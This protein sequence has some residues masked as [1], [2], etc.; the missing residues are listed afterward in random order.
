MSDNNENKN[1]ENNNENNININDN[2]VNNDN[3][4]Y[5]SNDE[6]VGQCEDIKSDEAIIEQSDNATESNEAISNESSVNE[7][8]QD[9][10]L[11]GNVNFQMVTMAEEKTDNGCESKEEEKSKE[12]CYKETVKKKSKKY[13]NAAFS[14][15]AA[16][17]LIIS[18]AGGG[19]IGASYSITQKIISDRYKDDD[20]STGDGTAATSAFIKTSSENS[21]EKGGAVP[22][23]KQVFPSVVSI[24]TKATMNK[25]Y[26]NG[27]S[28]PYEASG[29]GSGVIFYEDDTKVFIAT[30]DHVITGATSM[31]INFDKTEQIPATVVGTDSASDLAV[32]SV[33]KAD[34]KSA[35]IN[36]VSTA[37]FG[38]SDELEVG[39]SVIAIGNALGEGK[40]STGGMVSAAH[41][42]IVIDGKKLEVIQTDAAINPGNSGGAL[43]NYKGEVVGINT[44]KS[45]ESAVEGMGYAIP[46]NVLIPIIEKLL[47]DGSIEKP[48]LGIVGQDVTSEL[49]QLYGLPVG[50]IVINVLEGSSAQV[51]GIQEGDI[52]IDFGGDKIMNM[53]SLVETLENQTVGSSV[54]VRIIRN[55][56]DAMTVKVVIQDANKAQ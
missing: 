39:E 44:A 48:Y 49:S 22:I 28:V 32:I 27:L 14:R 24:T 36:E 3:D 35:G 40:T 33:L 11:D 10:N 15:F 34:L 20:N 46:S 55:G 51:A 45:F 21:S 30:N 25:S 37:T 47:T 31:Y 7:E 41:K 1:L 8:E 52:I 18:L 43:V 6:I 38:D 9:N 12:T 19:S 56:K 26:F 23:I 50:V 5:R 16:A 54:D 42:D 4:V 2:D 17:C 13:K 53:D 29:A